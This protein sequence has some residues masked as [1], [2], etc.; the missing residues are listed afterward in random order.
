MSDEEKRQRSATPSAP[1]FCDRCEDCGGRVPVRWC[2]P[3]EDFGQVFV[4]AVCCRRQGF[5]PEP[6]EERHL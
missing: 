2:V 5:E 4:C 6:I 3:N 1:L